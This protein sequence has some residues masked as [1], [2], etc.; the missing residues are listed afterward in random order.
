MVKQ[1]KGIILAG[2]KGTRL[3]PL[4]KGISK[5]LM[6]VYDK[7]MIYYPISTLM[8]AGIKDILIITNREYH[9][10]FRN[11]IGDGLEWGLSFKYAIQ[12]SPK[13]IADAFLIGKD[14]IGNSSVA[15]ILG[16]NLF[17][18]T[19]LKEKIQE[20]DQTNNGSVIFAY[21][22]IDPKHYG[23]VEFDKSEKVLSIEEKPKNPRSSYAITGLYFFDNTVIERSHNL[24]PS[25][26]GELEISSVLNTYLNDNL[27]I[28]KT[29]GRGMAWLD[30][31]TFDSLHEAGSYIKTLEKR[32]GLK[33]GCP[34]EIAWRNGWI[35]D[36][37]LEKISRSLIK[38]GYGSYLKNL[39]KKSSRQ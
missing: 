33:V 16:D 21:Q 34:E 36:S 20:A 26:R 19:G 25:K 18:G 23:V 14:F 32:Q 12:E 29:F 30:T 28:C 27:L 11:L 4:S 2:G 22:V 13:G 39:L 8:L 31:G 6:P 24:K 35:G 38:S 37:Q 15:L 10:L 5:Q 17:H 3:A 7:P 9:S 1:R